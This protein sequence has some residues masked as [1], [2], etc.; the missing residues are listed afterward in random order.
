M[1]EIDHGSPAASRL[2]HQEE[3]TV[4]ARTRISGKFLRLL[5]QA[6]PRPLAARPETEE[7]LPGTVE[8]IPECEI[9]E[10]ESP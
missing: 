5:W 8:T 6:S 2:L 3:A 1:R 4:K 10:E 9:G 7:S